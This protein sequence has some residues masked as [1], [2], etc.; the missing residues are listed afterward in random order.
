MAGVVNFEVPEALYTQ[1]LSLVEKAGKNG[2]V[3]I[4]VNEVTKAIERGTAKLVL[5]AQDVSPPEIVMHLPLL[6]KE[7]GIAFSYANTKEELGKRSGIAVG[8]SALA[9]LDEGDA[10]KELED[11]T[12]KLI[13]LSK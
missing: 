6:C 2:K 11:V 13:E 4:G 7:K 9:V 5:I 3:K 12:K 10:K 8:T 1:Q